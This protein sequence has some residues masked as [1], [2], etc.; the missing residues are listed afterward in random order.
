MLSA[1]SWNGVYVELHGIPVR[2]S[3]SFLGLRNITAIKDLKVQH[4]FS[5][6]IQRTVFI[7]CLPALCAPSRLRVGTGIF[8]MSKAPVLH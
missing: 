7:N 1:K 3:D 5:R 6:W 8:T 4:R 2:C